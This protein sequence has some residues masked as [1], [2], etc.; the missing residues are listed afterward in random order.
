MNDPKNARKEQRTVDEEAGLLSCHDGFP[1]DDQDEPYEDCS[2]RFCYCM[3]Y[4]PDGGKCGD[5][6]MGVH[7][8]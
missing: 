2:C 7:Q 1:E 6:Y 4:V 5:C 8:G 3:N